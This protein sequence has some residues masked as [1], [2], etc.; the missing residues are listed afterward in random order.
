MAECGNNINHLVS[1]L[2]VLVALRRKLILLQ[3]KILFTME[4]DT[5]LK[6]LRD[7]DIR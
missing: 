4:T 3:S 2:I 1:G 6:Y 5:K 7:G